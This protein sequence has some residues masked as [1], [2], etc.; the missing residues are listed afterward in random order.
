LSDS[1]L[2]Q[3]WQR[4]LLKAHHARSPEQ[5]ISLCG[6][7]PAFDIEAAPKVGQREYQ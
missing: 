3:A 1:A 4:A 7:L 5:R 2:V 6:E